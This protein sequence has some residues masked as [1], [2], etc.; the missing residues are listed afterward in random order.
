M[1]TSNRRLQRLARARQRATGEIYTQALAHVRREWEQSQMKNDDQK[2]YALPFHAS[3]GHGAAWE[4][5]V[6]EGDVFRMVGFVVQVDAEQLGDR[7][8]QLELRIGGS[9][10]LLVPS[11]PTRG[12]LRDVHEV[13][14][15]VADGTFETQTLIPML[16]YPILLYPNLAFLNAYLEGV[17]PRQTFPLVGAR[18]LCEK[19]AFQIPRPVPLGVP[20][21]WQVDGRKDQ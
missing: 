1:A 8:L 16:A 15:Q 17:Q 14:R 20:M 13:D 4:A 19:P 9:P 10:Q 12:Y 2:L 21:N 5:P 18:I 11:I 3:S 6:E 7:E